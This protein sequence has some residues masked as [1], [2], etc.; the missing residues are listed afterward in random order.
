MP[1]SYDEAEKIWDRALVEGY[2]LG[3][4]G[5]DLD[6]MVAERLAAVGWTEAEILSEMLI[7][8]PDSGL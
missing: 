8:Y 7:R 1:V 2:D 3:F 5:V 4:R 6:Q